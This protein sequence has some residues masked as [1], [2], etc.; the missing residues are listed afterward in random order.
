MKWRAVMDTSILKYM[1][2]IEAAEQKRFTKA[3]QSLNY[4]QSGISRMIAD[5][6][7]QWG[8]TLLERGRNGVV[9]T[10][11]G[12]RIL[13][14]AKKLC[15]DFESLRNELDGLSGVQSGLIRIG[16]FSS[17]ATHWLPKIIKAF[18]SDYPGVD[19][20]L[21]L[22]DYSEIE[23]WLSE[24]RVDCGFLRLPTLPQF[25]TEVLEKDSFVAV[26]PI[27]HPLEKLEKI[28]LEKNVL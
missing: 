13:P 9:P 25:H 15:G 28:P 1:A 2:F 22:G 17:V 27:G 21:L 10:S 23:R 4:S 3:A 7:K 8:I 5:L 16:T 19:Y 24:G 20:E 18:Q 6:E 26:L 14:L 12:L 11:D